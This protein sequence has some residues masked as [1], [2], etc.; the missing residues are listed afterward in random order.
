MSKSCIKA[1]YVIN[2]GYMDIDKGLMTAN[3]DIG[4][5]IKIPVPVFLLDTTEGYVMIDTG[6]N[7]QVIDDPVPCWGE[8]LAQDVPVHMTTE[9][10]FRTVFEKMGV[11]LDDIK[12]IINTHM[13]H[14]H[15][16][17]NRFF[18]NATH[19]V[20]KEEYR[21]AICPDDGFSARYTLH[22]DLP[23]QLN[24][25]LIEGECEVLPGIVLIP[26]PGHSPGHQS[27][28][29]KDVPGVGNLVYCG[30]AVYMKENWE[31]EIGPGICWNPPL[32]IKSML[33]LKQ[34]AELTDSYVFVSHDWDYFNTLP[35]A[36]EQF[37]VK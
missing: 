15:L 34:I 5:W 36:P 26:T 29:L 12:Y 35:M 30:D 3:T 22:S 20:Q 32:A 13:H 21:F 25:K 28:L 7:P 24:W 6:M 18:P 11:K 9:N 27:I 37:K 10:D 14:D 31:K 8:W 16:G 4:K 33:K 17:G 19:I 2:G 1:M 23:E